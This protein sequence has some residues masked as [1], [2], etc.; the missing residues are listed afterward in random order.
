MPQFVY[1]ARDPKGA[2]LRGRVEAKD[3]NVAANI[4]REK[5]LFI[6]SLKD[7]TE[8]TF[9]EV[10]AYFSK[11]TTD[12]IV[13]FTR[14]MATMIN[15][16][17]PLIQAFS[18]LQNQAK[19]AMRK[20]VKQL[21]RE[22]ESGENLGNALGKQK[23]IFDTVYI[24]LVKAGEAAGALDTILLRLAE[25]MEKQKEFRSKTKGALIYPAIVFIAMI[26]VMIIMMVFV[27][28]KMTALYEDFGADLP[29]ATQ[30]LIDLSKF[31]GSYWYALIGVFVGLGMAFRSWK[32]TQSGAFQFDQIMLAL[33]VF[34][35]L[36]KKILVTEFSRTMSLMIAAGISLLEALEIVTG[37][38]DNLVYKQ[39]I[40]KAKKDVEKGQPL[41][42]SIERQ[43]VFPELLPQMIAVGEETGQLDDVL[44]KLAVYYES[45]TE[46]AIKGMTTAIEPIIMI[47]LGLGVGFLIIAIVMPIYNLTSQF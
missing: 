28:P 20:V 23:G 9:A 1:V 33:P 41:S 44:K 13:N 19:P 27:V 5:Q 21:T 39:A 10:Q 2:K 46:Q 6:I 16:G 17:L 35:Q 4:L 11:V 8:S 29:F 22:V 18:I 26:A 15:A 43:H 36:R 25:T 42:Q 38:L 34:G 47:V 40:V 32:R 7:H 45:E 37:G 24:S 12:D 31:F 3:I 14:Q 30:A